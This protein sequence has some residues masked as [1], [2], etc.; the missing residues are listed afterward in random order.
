M[1]KTVK[2]TTTD[3]PV[4]TVE[5]RYAAGNPSGK[6]VKA[7]GVRYTPATADKW[8]ATVSAAQATIAQE[9][10]NGLWGGVQIPLGYADTPQGFVKMCSERLTARG[11]KMSKAQR[12]SFAER[13]R[14]TLSN[15]EI[16]IVTGSTDSTIS[17]YFT[18]LDTGVK[19]TAKGMGDARRKANG[20]S[21]DT[22]DNNDGPADYLAM[23]TLALR[24]LQHE[25]DLQAVGQ[26][27]KLAEKIRDEI[28]VAA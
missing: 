5:F 27:I 21:D 8:L 19:P 28:L 25:G 16:A 20:E 17:R 10:L 22:N 14:G 15:T 1:G 4:V 13:S 11:L 12:E 3:A 23:G 24:K 7:D 6:T 2:P 9:M 26:L 18:Y